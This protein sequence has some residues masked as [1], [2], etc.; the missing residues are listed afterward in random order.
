MIVCNYIYQ[1]LHY[2]H[3]RG[4][5]GEILHNYI[6]LPQAVS[7]A[8]NRSEATIQPCPRFTHSDLRHV[9]HP[10]H[11]P[12]AAIAFGDLSVDLA[13]PPGNGDVGQVESA[14]LG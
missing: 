14:S 6:L 3:I 13:I 9:E 8:N 11:S 10:P 12:S 5:N 2:T 4:E 1:I 7:Q